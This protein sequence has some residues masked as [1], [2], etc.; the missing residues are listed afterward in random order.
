M[1]STTKTVAVLLC[2]VTPGISAAQEV[3]GAVTLG[4]GNSDISGVSE[5]LGTVSVDGRVGVDFGNGFRFGIDQSAITGDIDG[6]PEDVSVFMLGAYGSYRFANGMSLGGYAEKAE[7]DVDG[8]ATDLSATSFGLMAG[9]DAGAAYLSGFAGK[10]TTDPDLPAGA[11]IRDIGVAVKY[12]AATNF[13]LGASAMRTR[14]SDSTTDL[15]VSFMG[16]AGAYGVAENWSLFGGLSRSSLDL[17]D[18]DITTFGVGVS[19]DLSSH[20]GMGS[21]VSLELARSTA[22]IAGVDDDLDTVRLGLSIPLGGDSFSVPMNSVADSVMAPRHNA[23]TST[24]L[25]AF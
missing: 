16:V 9:Y 7:L 3:G 4:Y 5:D 10:T 8:L 25:S 24:V 22:S 12:A 13:T 20:I 14:I 11:D 1:K 2:A 18:A 17:V 6:V 15:D 21:S 19:Y 23:I